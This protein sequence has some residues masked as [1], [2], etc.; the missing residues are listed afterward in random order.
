[1]LD[2]TA[3]LSLIPYLLAAGYALKLTLTRETYEDERLPAG[4]W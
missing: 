1:M 2:L 3:A 4:T